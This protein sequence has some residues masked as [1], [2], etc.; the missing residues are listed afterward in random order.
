[1]C[2]IGKSAETIMLLG[3]TQGGLYDV[4][5]HTNDIQRH[6]YRVAVCL[7]IAMVWWQTGPCGM[8]SEHARLVVHLLYIDM[9]LT[10]KH[11]YIC[12]TWL[13]WTHEHDCWVHTSSLF[14]LFNGKFPHGFLLFPPFLNQILTQ[15]CWTALSWRWPRFWGR[16][17]ARGT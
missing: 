10:E 9:T 1:V 7:W 6:W 3:M 13:L 11:N 8:G 2:G 5:W 4:I 17:A 14:P 15:V 12:I 16:T